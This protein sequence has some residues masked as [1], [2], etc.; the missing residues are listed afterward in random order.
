MMFRDM[1]SLEE[2]LKHRPELYRRTVVG[3]IESGIDK[4]FVF[5]FAGTKVTA[6]LQHKLHDGWKNGKERTQTSMLLLSRA[7]AR[8]QPDRKSWEPQLVPC[9]HL[10]WHTDSI[11]EFDLVNAQEMGLPFSPVMLLFTSETF[12]QNVLQESLDTIKRSWMKDHWKSHCT[13]WQS[14]QISVHRVTDC[15]KQI[16]SKEARLTRKCVSSIL[17]APHRKELEKDTT[18][19]LRR[20]YQSGCT[21]TGVV[22]E[23]KKH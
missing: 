13:H 15:L 14:K 16:F 7:F 12:L 23:T 4:K 11:Y 22:H 8:K 17:Q 19:V 20:R 5:G 18:S 1:E 6:A 3:T 21:H 10:K 9:V 2:A